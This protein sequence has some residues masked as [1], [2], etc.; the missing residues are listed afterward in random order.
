MS[1]A[2][3]RDFTS[4]SPQLKQPFFIGDGR[5][6]DGTVQTFTVP[7]GATRLYLGVHDNVNWNNNSGYFLVSMGAT[8]ATIKTVK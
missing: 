2:A 7:S 5:R 1:T 6:S 8:A 4:F 3:S